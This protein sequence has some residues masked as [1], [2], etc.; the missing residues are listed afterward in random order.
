MF[1]GSNDALMMIE[2]LHNG[3]SFKSLV[4][5][6]FIIK[7]LYGIS[8]NFLLLLLYTMSPSGKSFH[9]CNNTIVCKGLMTDDFVPHGS[10]RGAS[11]LFHILLQPTMSYHQEKSLQ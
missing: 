4:F 2:V 3:V 9:Q 7:Y 11:L 8:N 6:M 10:I 1:G 5:I